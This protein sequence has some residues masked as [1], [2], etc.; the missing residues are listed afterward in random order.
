MK[1]DFNN[2]SPKE[3]FTLIYHY[4]GYNTASSSGSKRKKKKSKSGHRE[5]IEGLKS[6]YRK[7]SGV[8]FSPLH[9]DKFFEDV[10]DKRK[11]SSIATKYT[12]GKGPMLIEIG[13]GR[14]ASLS[15]EHQQEINKLNR[16]KI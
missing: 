13:R 6:E 8:E 11:K 7:K 5:Y 9:F 15:S 12:A 14:N 2:L 3:L 16:K 1:V 4:D 10:F